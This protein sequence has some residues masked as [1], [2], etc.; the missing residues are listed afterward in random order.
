[1]AFAYDYLPA[2]NVSGGIHLCLNAERWSVSDV[3][4]GLCQAGRDRSSHDPW[5]IT[6]VYGP[7]LDHEK[8]EFLDELL[9]FRDA[10]S[11]PWFLCGDF[12]RTFNGVATQHQ[13]RIWESCSKRRLTLGAWQGIST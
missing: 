12:K 6:V 4:K 3:T 10:C 8:V 5:W 2:I 1:M 11:G 9:R 13:Q 7:Q